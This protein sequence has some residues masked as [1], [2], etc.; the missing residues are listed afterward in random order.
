MATNYK[1]SG[2]VITITAPGTVSAGRAFANGSGISGV[3]LSDATSGQSVA[4]Q[5]KGVFTITKNTAADVI[6]IGDPLYLDSDG[7]ID[8][9]YTEGLTNFIGYAVSASGNGTT[10]VDVLLVGGNSNTGVQVANIADLDQTI[11]GAYVQAEVQAISDK[12]DA[13]LVALKTAGVMIAD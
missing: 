11:S 1:N 5:I 4:L 8:P 7:E 12:V 2:D 10:T 3:F 13:L 6:S 9:A